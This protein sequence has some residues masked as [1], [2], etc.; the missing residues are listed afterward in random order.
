ML[1]ITGIAIALFSFK[2]LLNKTDAT[3]ET[4][5]GLTIFHYSKPVSKYDILGSVK[6]PAICSDR[7]DERIKHLVERSKKDFPS[8]EALIVNEAFGKAEVI[9]FK[10]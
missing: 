8:G 6:V 9:K 7:S 10:D 4:N 5:N 1:L 3:A 2:V